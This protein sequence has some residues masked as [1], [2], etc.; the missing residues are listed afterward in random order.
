MGQPKVSIIVPTYNVEPYLR[1]CLDSVCRQTLE[2]IEII[3]V[4]DG[5]TDGSLAIINEYAACDGRIVV[6]DGPNGGYGKGMNRG[7]DRATGEYIG[8]VEPDDFIAL[9]MYEDLYAI[10]AKHDLDFVKADFYRFTREEN[11]DMELKYN[12]LDKT[13]TWY[14]KMFDP[15]QEPE[16]LR[17][18]MNTWSG[19]YRRQFL[20]EYG[21][22]HHETPGASFQDNGFWMQTFVYG[23]RAMIVDKPYYRNRRDNPNSSVKDTGKVYCMNVEYDYIE[24]M[25]RKDPDLWERFK[26]MFW[27]KRF[28]NYTFTLSRIDSSF[29]PEYCER[30][31][32]DFL[33]ARDLGELDQTVFSE[34]Q[35]GELQAIFANPQAF[36]K[37]YV[38]RRN[39]KARRKEVIESARGWARKVLK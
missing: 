7:L 37:R 22:R 5:S 11:G 1:E 6:L 20:E 14:N 24:D 34:K 23:R 25:L 39:K 27:L 16:T 36:A 10:A 18:I 29:I 9:T 15:S 4:N 30:I 12:H 28:G 8:I 31:R 32:E 2:D 17:F 33:R 13:N 26:A 38:A 21:I 3:C 35:W 19:I